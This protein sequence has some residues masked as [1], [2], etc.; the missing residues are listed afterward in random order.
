MHLFL[1][2]PKIEEILKGRSARIVMAQE[3]TQEELKHA[4]TS[5]KK[6]AQ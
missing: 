6:K 5:T 1:T 2:K 3:Q 4:E